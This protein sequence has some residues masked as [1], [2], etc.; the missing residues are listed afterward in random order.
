MMGADPLAAADLRLAAAHGVLLAAIV[1]AHGEAADLRS[2][3]VAIERA[4]RDLR[5][6][7]DSRVEQEGDALDVAS[8][9][10]VA[11]L[12]RLALLLARELQE[13]RRHTCNSIRA[14]PGIGIPGGRLGRA[15]ASEARVAIVRQPFRRRVQA[16]CLVPVG[17]I[18]A[19]KDG[20]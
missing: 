8:A 3:L 19:R 9:E 5:Q 12:A 16:Y 14:I 15:L 6:C 1:R 7:A 10:Q 4:R 11:D 18:M 17:G 20:G 2:A 13:G